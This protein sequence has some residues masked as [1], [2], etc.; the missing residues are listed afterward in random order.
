MRLPRV[1]SKLMVT[2]EI[3]KKLI[4]DQGAWAGVVPARDDMLETVDSERSSG[5]GQSKKEL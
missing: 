5:E 3:L 1:I 4:Q 2:G